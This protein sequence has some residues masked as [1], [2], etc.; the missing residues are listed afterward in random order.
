M[1]LISEPET[2]TFT[3]LRVEKLTEVIADIRHP[4]SPDVTQTMESQL[5]S[6][7]YLELKDDTDT[8]LHCLAIACELVRDLPAKKLSPTLQ[9]LVDTLVG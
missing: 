8:L 2:L 1:S 5:A 7:S 3:S 6:L 9:T 4:A